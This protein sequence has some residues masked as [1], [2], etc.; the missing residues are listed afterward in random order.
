MNTAKA[1]VHFPGF[2][3]LL[4]TLTA[5]ILKHGGIKFSIYRFQF[6]FLCFRI[7]ILFQCIFMDVTRLIIHVNLRQS[8]LCS[9]HGSCRGMAH[10]VGGKS[11]HNTIVLEHQLVLAV[12]PPPRGFGASTRNIDYPC[13]SI[14]DTSCH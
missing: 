6:N 2:F 4:L 11:P 14:N 12:V 13:T 9:I 10:A 1:P 7:P 3:H 5:L 8:T